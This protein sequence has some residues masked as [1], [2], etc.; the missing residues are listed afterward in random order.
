MKWY[1]NLRKKFYLG[2]IDRIEEQFIV[3][4][5]KQGSPLLVAYQAEDAFDKIRLNVR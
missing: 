4:V 2:I 1:A 3:N 5:R